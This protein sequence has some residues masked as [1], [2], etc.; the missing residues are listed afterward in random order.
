[1]VKKDQINNNITV[2]TAL[3]FPY[4]GNPGLSVCR[5]HCKTHSRHTWHSTFKGKSKF[6][7]EKNRKLLKM[8]SWLN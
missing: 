4:E 5:L 3:S 7:G 1:M 6:S 8:L 2:Q